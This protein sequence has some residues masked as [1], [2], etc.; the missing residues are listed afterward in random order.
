MTKRR[1]AQLVLLVGAL[2]VFYFLSRAWPKDQVVR[3]DLGAAAA[4]RVTDLRVFFGDSEHGESWHYELGKAPRVVESDVRLP[5]GDYTVEID[6]GAGD[7]RASAT[8]KLHLE[9]GSTT[10]IDL[11]REVPE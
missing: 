9:S 2:G 8:R 4:P 11:S 1:F 7:K 5:D 3:F 10:T 6:V